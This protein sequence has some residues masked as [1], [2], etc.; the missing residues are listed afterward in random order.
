[1]NFIDFVLSFFSGIFNPKSKNYD[2]NKVIFRQLPFD[3]KIFKNDTKI[4]RAE[5]SSD[6]FYF[7]IANNKVIGCYY[8]GSKDEEV[9]QKISKKLE[10]DLIKFLQ[11]NSNYFKDKIDYKAHNFLSEIPEEYKYIRRR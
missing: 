7:V 5:V 11:G 9:M 1:M 4:V 2:K 3:I 6:C 10:E 8:D